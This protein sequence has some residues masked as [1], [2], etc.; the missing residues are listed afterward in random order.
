MV[1][2][3]PSCVQ[4]APSVLHLN[5]SWSSSIDLTG[6]WTG[7]Q[8]NEGTNPLKSLF[9]SRLFSLIKDPPEALPSAFSR[10]EFAPPHKSS[11]I[12]TPWNL[13]DECGIWLF[14]GLVDYLAAAQIPLSSWRCAV[15]VDT[16]L[17]QV[18]PQLKYQ[19]VCGELGTSGKKS[20]SPS[21][22]KWNRK[23]KELFLPPFGYV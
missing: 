2:S 20:L 18:L 16:W 9:M 19:R 8:N 13:T 17:L 12:P 22:V 6:L 21:S 15:K 23:K 4:I 3:D 5:P 1:L 11:Y 10:E 7:L 14:P